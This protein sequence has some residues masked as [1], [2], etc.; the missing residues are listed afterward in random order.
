M[1]KAKQMYLI[2]VWIIFIQ[3]LACFVR[4]TTEASLGPLI[5][6]IRWVGRSR[7]K[8]I[9]DSFRTE[10]STNWLFEKNEGRS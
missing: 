3:F 1:I 10:S 9:K 7:K 8:G 2:I 4:I 5:S 6:K